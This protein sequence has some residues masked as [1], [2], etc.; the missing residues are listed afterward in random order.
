MDLLVALQIFLKWVF[1]FSNPLSANSGVVDC[2]TEKPT[3]AAH[4]KILRDSQPSGS[5]FFRK[6]CQSSSVMSLSF[7]QGK[8]LC[9][10]KHTWT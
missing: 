9:L 8:V 5:T 1:G 3:V 2:R 6:P 10:S 7:C 4:F